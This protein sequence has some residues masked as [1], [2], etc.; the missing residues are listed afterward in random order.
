MVNTSQPHVLSSLWFVLGT[1]T[2]VTGNW[3]SDTPANISLTVLY[4]TGNGGCTT[5]VLACR[6]ITAHAAQVASTC[7]NYKKNPT[8][9]T[10]IVRTKVTPFHLCACNSSMISSSLKIKLQVLLISYNATMELPWPLSSFSVPLPLAHS[11]PPALALY[12]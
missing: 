9:W 8:R 3:K 10:G 7:T 12:S 11:V 4:L 1:V 6:W 5:R 2:L